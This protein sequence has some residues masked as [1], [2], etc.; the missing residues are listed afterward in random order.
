MTK[1][2]ECHLRNQV[3]KDCNCCSLSFCVCVSF[4]LLFF[5]LACS[6]EA[7]C[8][9]LSYP[10]EKP[11]WQGTKDSLSPTDSKE[12][13]PSP[14]SSPCTTHSIYHLW[15]N[16]EVYIF[17]AEAC[18]DYCPANSLLTVCEILWGREP[19]FS[20][21]KEPKKL[22]YNKCHFKPLSFW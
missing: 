22:W 15:M 18:D 7:S 13:R 6:H 4:T 5:S 8:H 11:K 3:K 20:R 10:M 12:M 19:R 1:E 9:I 2:V 21:S 16:M 17:S 14:H